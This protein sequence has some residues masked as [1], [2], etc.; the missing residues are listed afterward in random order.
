MPLSSKKFLQKR[1]PGFTLIELS[2][3]MIIIGILAAGIFKGK[4]LIEQ[5]RLQSTQD[6]FNRIKLAILQYREQ[7]SQWP[8]NDSRATF[9]GANSRAGDGSG[10]IKQDE[11]ANVWIH[12]EK[13]GLIDSP[14]SP[15]GKAGG[16]FSV[17]GNPTQDHPGNWIILSGEAGTLSGALTPKQTLILKSKLDEIDPNRGKLRVINGQGQTN[18]LTNTGYNTDNTSPSCVIM[19]RVD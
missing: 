6:E 13:A 4:D 8:G 14:T 7:F 1:V 18:C 15:R 9:L 3:V 5:A 16:Y 19:M 12:L 2:I 11:S 10:I 17:L